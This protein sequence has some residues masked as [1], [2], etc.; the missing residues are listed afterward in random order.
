MRQ[1]VTNEKEFEMTIN[2]DNPAKS[3]RHA[4]MI[5]ALTEI[6]RAFKVLQI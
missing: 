6:V 2:N 1:R 3:E 5:K 4:E